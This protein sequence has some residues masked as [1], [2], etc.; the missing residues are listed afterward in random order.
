MDCD[1]DNSTVRRLNPLAGGLDYK[2]GGGP[3]EAWHDQKGGLGKKAAVVVW[4]RFPFTFR[5]CV[6]K[7][8]W[9]YLYWVLRSFP[10]HF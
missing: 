5:A 10:T 8:A 6:R 1:S 7:L 2:K 4:Q 3:C 9:I